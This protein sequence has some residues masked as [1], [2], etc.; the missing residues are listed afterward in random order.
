MTGAYRPYPIIAGPTASGKTAVAVALAQRLG[1]E[2]V[3]A[4]SMQIYAD[5]AVGTARPSVEEMQGV[6]HYLIGFLPLTENYSVA[7][8]VTDAGR[9]FADIYARG[10]L[11]L[12]CGGTGLY[13]QSF[14][15]NVQF[16]EQET[17]RALREELHRQ[18]AA[19][20]G[21][22]MLARLR[23]VDSDTAA[24]LH[25]NDLNR[26][27]RALE[28]YHTTGRTISEQARLSKALP[29]PYTPCL[30]VLNYRDRAV[31][32]ERIDRRVEQMLENGLLDEARR[33]LDVAPHATAWQ[34]IGYKELIPYLHGER[35]LEE[36]VER[37]KISTHQYAKRQLSWFRRMD[38]V[39]TVWMDDYENAAMAAVA[40]EQVY[41]QYCEEEC[42]L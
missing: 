36:A 2:V 28:V 14:A 37:L 10:G 40:I 30:F 23:A 18:A 19:E 32:R 42:A 29:S 41:R 24:R 26:I 17:D 35:S 15:E 11:P 5:I 1:A 3:S 9:V 25:E 27:I 34:A 21:A 6:P 13:I 7:R 22:A 33:M 20:G 16:F 39:H 12:L 38:G 4:D 8:Y 31:L